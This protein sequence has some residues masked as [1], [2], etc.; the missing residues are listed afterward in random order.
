MF[1]DTQ[2]ESRVPI[3]YLL[4][5]LITL[6]LSQR[7]TNMSPFPET[8]LGIPC[9]IILMAVVIK[10][11]SLIIRLIA[12]DSLRCQKKRNRTSLDITFRGVSV[13]CIW[14]SYVLF[15]ALSSFQSFRRCLTRSYCPIN[16]HFSIHRWWLHRNLSLLRIDVL[17]YRLFRGSRNHLS[18]RSAP[19]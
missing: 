7:S 18:S 8:K 4:S 5:I 17:H 9:I 3:E 13:S 12:F 1:Q 10:F 16:W 6:A 15:W 2:K 11:W 19:E 14:A